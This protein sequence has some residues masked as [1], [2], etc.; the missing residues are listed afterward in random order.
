MALSTASDGF[1]AFP[2]TDYTSGVS[3]EPDVD[4]KRVLTFSVP[5]DAPATLFYFCEWHSGMGGQISITDA[6]RSLM[7]RPTEHRLERREL[8]KSPYEDFF[9]RALFSVLNIVDD[10]IVRTRKT[11]TLKRPCNKNDNRPQILWQRRIH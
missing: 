3:T 9:A 6:R 11:N 5:A 1:H 8:A 4:G 7:L 2:N 10:N